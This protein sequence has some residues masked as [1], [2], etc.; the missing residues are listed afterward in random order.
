MEKLALTANLGENVD[1]ADESLW[2]SLDAKMKDVL[3]EKYM[4]AQTSVFAPG[5][6]AEREWK[7]ALSSMGGGRTYSSH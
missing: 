3:E 2:E 7:T 1:G 4:T 5:N 6:I